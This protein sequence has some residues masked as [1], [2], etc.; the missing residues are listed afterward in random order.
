M[1]VSREHQRGLRARPRSCTGLPGHGPGRDG[2]CGGTQRRGQ[3][4]PAQDHRRIHDPR[5]GHR[6]PGRPDRWG[7]PR[8]R[9]WPRWGCA[10]CSRT[11]G[12]SPSSPCAR[13]S[14]WRPTPPASLCT[15]SSSGWSASIPRSEVHRKEGRRPQRGAAPD[16][17]FRAGP[18]GAPEVLLVD[19]PTEG[20]AAGVIDDIFRLLSEMKGACPCSSSSRT[21]RWC[22]ARRPGLRHEGR[23]DFPG[24][25]HPRGNRGDRRAGEEPVTGKLRRIDIL[26][27]AGAFLLL[28]PFL[29]FQRS[30]DYMISAFSCSP[31]TSST[32]HGPSLVRA[33]AVP[34]LRRLRRDAVRGARL[35]EPVPLRP[36]RDRCRRRGRGAAGAHRRPDDGAAFALINLAFNQVGHFLVL[37]AFARYTGGQDGMSADFSKVGFLDFQDKRWMYVFCLA[38][39]LLT[40]WGIAAPTPRSA[41]FCG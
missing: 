35:A 10:T 41:S 12:S 20:L 28:L 36:V 40:C 31:S 7:E 24:T 21:C 16:P 19:E 11:S 4:H 27:I 2:L 37:I 3:D 17:A 34:G 29:N 26:L 15:T 1:L 6:H 23:E 5:G 33:H 18:D 14:N 39:L 8:R 30:T 38:C 32:A 9:R 13:T 25:R 22:R